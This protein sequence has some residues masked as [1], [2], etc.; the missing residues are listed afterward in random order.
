MQPPPSSASGYG[1]STLVAL[2]VTGMIGSGVFTTSGYALE[3]LGSADLVLA[4]WT[5]AGIVALC[6]AVAY[7]ALAI[8]MPQSG[9]E[10]LY[11]SRTVHPFAGFLA[12]LISII[13]GFAG[14]T[15]L[16][17]LACEKYA[18]PLLPPDMQ[19]PRATI[20]TTVVL[21][22][23]VG[24]A[25]AG[26]L[27][28]RLTTA[29][30]A[31]KMLAIGG[32]IVAGR[33]LLGG[34]PLPEPATAAAVPPA[35]FAATVMWMM[36]SYIGFNEAIYVAAEARRPRR[37]VPLALLLGTLVTT[38]TYLLLNDVILRAAPVATLAGQPDVAAIAA[39]ALGGPGF[40]RCMRGAIVLS[41]FAAVAG[42]MM[43][44]PRVTTCMADD[45]LLPR[46]FAGGVGIGRAAV[47]QT[48][49]AVALVQQT[50]ILGLLNYL[51]VTLSLCSACTVATLWLPRPA[52][53]PR[54]Q[55]PPARALV[56]GV[57][58]QLATA[59][60]VAATLLFVAVLAA[61]EPRHLLGTVLTLMAAAAVWPFTGGR[62]GTIPRPATH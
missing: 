46:C 7:G 20:A 55:R 6:G 11:L 40:E 26:R 45:G 48:L 35:A 15:A 32:L 12:G 5:A 47:L 56:T 14:S 34:R 59:V 19:L 22:C 52:R 51:G 36:Y 17:A 30:V 60:Y 16:A 10:Y 9:G 38:V 58:V 61:D 21:L 37:T 42:M 49:L 18:A 33:S 13:A 23:G 1:L 2:V 50:T 43:A 28:V 39:A 57:G 24:H 27:A 31:V 41:T 53:K 3:S 44:G 25:L 62:H 8:R 29:I 54:Q 4:A